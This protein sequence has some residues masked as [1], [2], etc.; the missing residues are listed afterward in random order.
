MWK[1]GH[2]TPVCQHMSKTMPVAKPE[3]WNTKNSWND[4]RSSKANECANWCGHKEQELPCERMKVVSHQVMVLGQT[5]AKPQ[6]VTVQVEGK[7]LRM[8]IN[9]G[10]SVS[11][12]SQTLA[13]PNF[14]GSS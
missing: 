11:V 10:A 8:E 13:S 1:K 5:T 2:I 9:T 14:L 12:M 7:S 4:K 3:T 6:I